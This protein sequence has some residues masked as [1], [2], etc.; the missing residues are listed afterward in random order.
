MLPTGAFAVAVGIVCFV[1]IAFVSMRSGPR[2]RPREGRG[3]AIIPLGDHYGGDG[4]DAL[5]L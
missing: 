2:R 1:L 3:R 4:G 5:D